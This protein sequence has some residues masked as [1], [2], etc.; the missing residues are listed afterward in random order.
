MK[1]PRLELLAY[2]NN[3]LSAEDFF[4]DYLRTAPPADQTPPS[5]SDEAWLDKHA[6]ADLNFQALT[7]AE[8]S[9]YLNCVRLLER[10]VSF[11]DEAGATIPARR[12]LYLAFQMARCLFKQDPASLRALCSLITYSGTTTIRRDRNETGFLTIEAPLRELGRLL[13]LQSLLERIAVLVKGITTRDNGLRPLAKAVVR[14]NAELEKVIR[15]VKRGRR[16]GDAEL[17]ESMAEMKSL[18]PS[19]ETWLTGFTTLVN[20]LEDSLSFL[21]KHEAT[22]DVHRTSIH[23]SWISTMVGQTAPHTDVIAHEVAHFV[24]LTTDLDHFMTGFT[25]ARRG[26]SHFAVA[27]D[28]LH[29]R[30]LDG[31]LGFLDPYARTNVLEFFAVSAEHFFVD[32]AEIERR[33]PDLCRFL[34]GVFGYQPEPQPRLATTGILKGMFGPLSI[35]T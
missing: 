28:A 12:R 7:G 25:A 30:Y 21:R 6:R 23:L 18:G 22:S 26:T 16:L 15:K 4:A 34:T 32:S 13:A 17:A 1:G 11:L 19:I 3:E 9:Q 14:W 33:A 5:A 29:A 20:S 10:N 35:F 31:E 2:L 27:L 24:H 8:R